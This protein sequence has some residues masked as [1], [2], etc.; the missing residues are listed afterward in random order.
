MKNAADMILMLSFSAGLVFTSCTE[1]NAG[2]T[3]GNGD[4]THTIVSKQKKVKSLSDEDGNIIYSFEYD[5]KDRLVRYSFRGENR[6]SYK[7][8]DNRITATP[9]DG[10]PYS[11][12][13]H[14][15]DEGYLVS[16]DMLCNGE[17]SET[18]TMQY[19]DGFLV[20]DPG[21]DYGYIYMDGNLVYTYDEKGSYGELAYYDIPY[22]L[23][24]DI[25]FL[26]NMYYIGYCGYDGYLPVLKPLPGI[27]SRN[28]LKRA[29]RTDAGSM[30]D[31]EYEY[32][33]DSDGNIS[34]IRMKG[35]MTYII[36]GTEHEAPLSEMVLCVEY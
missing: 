31:V 17:I 29:T 15:D 24:I 5:D 10:H 32:T 6:M 8:K 13:F 4:E 1:D 7:Y 26:G 20:A 21:G 9:L 22:D 36:D 3:Y 33:L 35:V 16:W 19:I 2:G 34:E 14:F 30:L 27:T 23:S 25:Q 28:C 11:Y 18:F 12:D